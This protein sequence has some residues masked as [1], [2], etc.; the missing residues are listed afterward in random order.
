MLNSLIEDFNIPPKDYFQIFNSHK[1]EEIYYDE[2][3]LINGNRTEGVL[4]IQIT[5][6]PGRTK[7]QKKSL[8]M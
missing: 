6:G 7:E 8:Y 3:Y 5:C 4:Y 2:D 1:K